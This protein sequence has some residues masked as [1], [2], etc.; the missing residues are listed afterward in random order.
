MPQRAP[1]WPINT[2]E[3]VNVIKIGDRIRKNIGDVTRLAESMQIRGLINPVSIDENNQLICGARRLAA[4]KSLGWS[5]IDV[6][7]FPVGTD[8]AAAAAMEVEENECREPFTLAEA[9]AYYNSIRVD[10]DTSLA[11]ATAAR[12]AS[13]TLNAVDATRGNAAG[14]HPGFDQTERVTGVSRAKLQSYRQLISVADDATESDDVRELASELV[15]MVESGVAAP[16]SAIRAV[17]D[18][19]GK[20][21]KRTKPTRNPLLAHSPH[22]SST[23]VMNRLVDSMQ[24]PQATLDL[25][26]FDQLELAHLQRW[27]S[28]LTDTIRSLTTIRNR[29]NKELTH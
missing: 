2:R 22:R 9:N 17:R 28:S 21:F 11:L 19:R 23:E 14:A 25:I 18:A 20:P 26:D 4:A 29:L 15:T 16:T 24:V 5:S 7:V 1:R 8:P 10:Q 6:R 3:D 27:V 13:A 12:S